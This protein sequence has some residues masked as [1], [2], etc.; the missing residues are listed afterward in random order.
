MGESVLPSEQEPDIGEL[1]S[2]LDAWVVQEGMEVDPEDV[3][4][5]FTDEETG[6]PRDFDDALGAAV[7]FLFEQGYD[8][9]EV[10]TE[11]GI[12]ESDE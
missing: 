2:A 1:R 12:L 4:F 3:N 9:H 10:L 7:G 6:E 8:G 11:A 5:L